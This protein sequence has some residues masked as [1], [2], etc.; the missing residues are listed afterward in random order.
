M[1]FSFADRFYHML[2]AENKILFL[3]LTQRALRGNGKR[4]RII[5]QQITAPTIVTSFLF[6]RWRQFDCHDVRRCYV[7]FS[8]QKLS[9]YK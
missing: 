4:Q 3:I 8:H 9:K 1:E 7:I 2:N 6:V 5:L